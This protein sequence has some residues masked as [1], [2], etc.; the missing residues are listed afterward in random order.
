MVVKSVLQATPTYTMS[1][2]QHL[3]ATLHPVSDFNS[4]WSTLFK[5][6]TVEMKYKAIESTVYV[7]ICELQPLAFPYIGV[8][9]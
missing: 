9:V 6:F 4:W 3:Q 7:S 1:C 2:F 8:K 5:G